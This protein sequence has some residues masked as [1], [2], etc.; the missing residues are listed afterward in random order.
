MS[1]TEQPSAPYTE[2]TLTEEIHQLI[3][4][5]GREHALNIVNVIGGLEFVKSQLLIAVN[6]TVREA[7]SQAQDGPMNYEANQVFEPSQS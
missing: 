1:N 5:R 6:D 3:T 2:A 7:A 4:D